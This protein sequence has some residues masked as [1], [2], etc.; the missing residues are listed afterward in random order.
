[1]FFVRFDMCMCG[2]KRLKKTGLAT[3]CKHLEG[4]EIVC[5]GQHEHLPF[6][7]KNGQFDTA[8]EAAYPAK[9]CHFA[10]LWSELWWKEA[11]CLNGIPLNEPTVKQSK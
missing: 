7:C 5:D 11:L 1:M 2:G 4:Y 10:I 8:A 9:F 3:N 6:G